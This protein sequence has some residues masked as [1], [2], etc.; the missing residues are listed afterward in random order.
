MRSVFT[1]SGLF[2]WHPRGDGYI[3]QRGDIYLNE[4]QHTAMCQSAIPDMLTEALISEFGTITGGYAI[5][6]LWANFRNM[7]P[8]ATPVW[9][10]S[11]AAHSG[12]T[13]VLS[14]DGRYAFQGLLR[15]SLR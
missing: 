1:S 15:H 14:Y 11:M 3:A 6:E 13:S 7:H 12:S 5:P 9:S 8:S 2:D 4:G 10:I